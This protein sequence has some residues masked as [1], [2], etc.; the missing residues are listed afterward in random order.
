MAMPAEILPAADAPGKPM[1][2]SGVVFLFRFLPIFFLLYFLVPKK[3]K[4]AVFPAGSLLFYAWG[5][6]V[7]IVLM[8][9]S[10]V[11]DYLHGMLIEKNRGKRKA[12]YFLLSSLTINLAMLGFF[13]YSGVNLPLPIG[14]SFYTFQT[15]SYVIDVYRGDVPAQKKPEISVQAVRTG[16]Y[17]KE[18]EEYVSAQIL[19]RNRYIAIKSATDK[20]LGK[21]EI[22]GVY[23]ATDGT[24][25]EKHTEEF[26]IQNIEKTLE[27]LQT[28]ERLLQGKNRSFQVLLAPTADNV[29]S[30]KLPAY[31][32][33]FPEEALWR[34]FR[35][36]CGK[37]T[38]FPDVFSP[39]RSHAEEY[40]YYGTDHHWTTLGSYYAYEGM[41]EV[42]YDL[43]ETP[44]YSL[45]AE[46]YLSGKNQYGY[47]LDDNHMLI[48]IRNTSY[49]KE[50]TDRE[51]KNKGT[52]L[53]IIKDSFAN[54][55]VPYLSEH[56]E[57]IYILDLRY[58]KGKLTQL[59]DRYVTKDT[60]VLI[61]YNMSHFVTEF[62]FWE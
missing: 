28:L 51:R 50:S 54:C 13:K 10:T 40:I 52:S 21:K 2:L 4:N 35:D 11:S 14:I 53:F 42:Y 49:K 41:R 26:S 16:S 44:E 30:E 46:K 31:A 61:L 57:T 37:N 6:P 43:S 24:L 39:L 60:D 38:V 22:N 5:E 8:L 12:F 56:Y 34:Q 15:M 33:V 29:Y 18:Y 20:A 25:I 48:E 47:F 55:M 9:F 7:Y 36:A 32:E 45:Y 3:A 1:V 62:R 58:Y 27:G 17:M 59:I 19:G 23:L